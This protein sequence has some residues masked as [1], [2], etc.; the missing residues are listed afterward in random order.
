MQ[1]RVFSKCSTDAYPGPDVNGSVSLTLNG[2]PV[3]GSPM[4]IGY[5]IT[6]K[7]GNILRVGIFLISSGSPRVR[8]MGRSFGA[9]DEIELTPMG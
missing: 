8:P 2:Q 4:P 5:A 9:P 6:K 3:P 7:S 1:V